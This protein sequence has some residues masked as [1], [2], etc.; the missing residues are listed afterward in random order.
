[1]ERTTC[2]VFSEI[3]T[4]VV[5]EETLAERAYLPQYGGWRDPTTVGRPGE[6]RMGFPWDEWAPGVLNKPQMG[7]LLE[8]GYITH[9]GPAP[10]LGHSSMDL[11]LADEAYEMLE[12]SVKPSQSPYDWFVTNIGLAKRLPKST[13]GIYELER[14]GTPPDR[15]RTHRVS[16]PLQNISLDERIITAG[17]PHPEAARPER[18]TETPTPSPLK[19]AHS[20]YNLVI[21]NS[22]LNRRP[23][24]SR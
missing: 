13:D 4:E 6:N 2:E 23:C 22:L 18:E 19:M 21:I 9:A 11:S 5:Q 3:S 10:K 14:Q 20:G 17:Q 24:K 7:K 15:G 8:G 16:Q 1:M 12:G